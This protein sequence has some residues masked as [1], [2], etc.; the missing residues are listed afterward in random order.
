MFLLIDL[1][2]F[3]VM[4]NNR[5][6]YVDYSI[7]MWQLQE[8]RKNRRSI[9]F[10]DLKGKFYSSRNRNFPGSGPALIVFSQFLSNI[11]SNILQYTNTKYRYPLSRNSCIRRHIIGNWSTHT[12]LMSVKNTTTALIRIHNFEISQGHL[13]QS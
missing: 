3:L 13:I 12:L 1:K 9:Q 7:F 6:H 2:C 5:P 10:R 11:F 4:H 8:A